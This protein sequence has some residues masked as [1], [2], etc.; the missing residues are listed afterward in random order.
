MENLLYLAAGIVIGAAIS[1]IVRLI[2]SKPIGVLREDRSDPDA[3]YL[4]LELNPGG[5][6]QIMK[7]KKVTFRVLRESYISATKT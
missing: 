7:R 3:P 1:T 6:A 2:F 5:Y 4:F